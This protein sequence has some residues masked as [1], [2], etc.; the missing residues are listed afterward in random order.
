MAWGHVR[1]QSFWVVV[2]VLAKVCTTQTSPPLSHPLSSSP[3]PSSHP[4]F[5]HVFVCVC[6]CVRTH[7]CVCTLM[8]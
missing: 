6:V 7:V 8:P 3:L 2:T 1:V 4:S 5:Y